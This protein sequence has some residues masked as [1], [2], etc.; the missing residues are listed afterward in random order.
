MGKSVSRLKTFGADPECSGNPEFMGK[1]VPHSKIFSDSANFSE[2]QTA[3]RNGSGHSNRP[4]QRIS[5]GK[6]F[7]KDP[8]YNLMTGQPAIFL[9]G[10]R[11]SAQQFGPCLYSELGSRPGEEEV[12]RSRTRSFRFTLRFRSG[13]YNVNPAPPPLATRHRV[14]AAFTR[15]LKRE[16]GVN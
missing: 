16:V 2:W 5:G 4:S 14:M 15:S 11:S 1:S 7:P 10:K 6:H 9:S 3:L 12:Y 13:W 8:E